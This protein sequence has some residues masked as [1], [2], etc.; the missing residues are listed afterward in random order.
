MKK[1]FRLYNI[2]FPMWMIWILPVTWLVI[3]PANILI[4]GLV[5]YLGLK[6]LKEDGAF[7]KM[8]DYLLKTVVFGFLSD[9]VGAAFLFLFMAFSVD[10]NT[11]FGKWWYKVIEGPV[12]YN[13]FDNPMA[14]LI[15]LIGVLISGFLIYF[16]NYN[17]NFKTRCIEEAKAKKLAI[18]MA[19]FTA[20]YLFLLPMK[21]FY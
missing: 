21:L 5:I 17:F 10:H 9:I 1:D 8:K 13:P 16:L 4:D 15:V 2:I 7:A 14:F 19:V 20:P 12:A 18:Y 11:D 6:Y 3:I